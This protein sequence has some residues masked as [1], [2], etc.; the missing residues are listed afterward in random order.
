MKKIFCFILITIIALQTNVFAN[1]ISY[2]DELFIPLETICNDLNIVPVI[3]EKTV[4]VGDSVLYLNKYTALK[5]NEVVYLSRP[6][7][8]VG[9]RVIIPHTVCDSVFNIRY[10]FNE[11]TL[12]YEKSDKTL[13]ELRPLPAKRGGIRER[14]L[15]SY[16]NTE[17]VFK[18][19]FVGG[20]PK[21]LVAKEDL[22]W[23]IKNYREENAL[24]ISNDKKQSAMYEESFPTNYTVSVTGVGPSIGVIGRMSKEGTFYEAY[25]SGGKIFLN[26]HVDGGKSVLYTYNLIWDENEMINMKIRFDWEYIYVYVDDQLRFSY[27]DVTTPIL[28]G[29]GGFSGAGGAYFK[30]FKV[31]K[32]IETE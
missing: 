15:Y 26:K 8:S 27:K 14:E 25:Y 19:S 1:R 30:D 17:V 9:G 31:L 28:S 23:S 20:M 12:K 32:K 22:G 4:T 21:S 7:Q 16:E 6:V 13:K 29:K 10:T 24:Y 2:D 5:G 18:E 3:T 11:G